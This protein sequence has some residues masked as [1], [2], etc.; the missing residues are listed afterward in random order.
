MSDGTVGGMGW[1][2]L[3]IVCVC[4]CVVCMV[5]HVA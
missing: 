4:V 3:G 2:V 5:G 1:V